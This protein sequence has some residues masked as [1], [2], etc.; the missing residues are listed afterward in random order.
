MRATL[1]CHPNADNTWLKTT[2]PTLRIQQEFPQWMHCINMQ[3]RS[4]CAEKVNKKEK[5][6]RRME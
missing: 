5:E 6:G 2:T 1:L 3:T 4:D